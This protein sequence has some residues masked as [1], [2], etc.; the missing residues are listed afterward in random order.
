[1]RLVEDLINTRSIEF[2]TDELGTADAVAAWLRAR[3]LLRRAEQVTPA[4]HRR[5]LRM[6]EGLRALIAANHG[7]SEPPA[8]ADLAALSDALP[9]VLDVTTR[10]P[11]LVP[12]RPGAVDHALATMLIA[13]ARSVDNG[14]WNRLKVCREPACRWAYY[15]HSRNR[16]RAWC[17]MATCGNRAKART[18]RRASAG[19]R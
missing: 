17:S 19:D 7:E 14:T 13:V 12:A 10:P 6:R 2:D 8:L 9:V 3:D 5:V 18:F 15:D 4:E 11:R 16:S 1:L